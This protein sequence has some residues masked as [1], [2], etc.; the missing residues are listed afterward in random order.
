[1]SPYAPAVGYCRPP[2]SRIDET[3]LGW[4]ASKACA[5]PSR[6]HRRPGTATRRWRVRS[7]DDGNAR[8]DRP[9][10]GRNGLSW[11]SSCWRPTALLDDAGVTGHRGHRV[12]APLRRCATLVAD[13]SYPGFVDLPAGCVGAGRFA[14]A[15]R[16]PRSQ[17]PNT[18]AERIARSRV[19]D[20]DVPERGAHR[21]VSRRPHPDVR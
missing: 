8:R 18:T 2:R 15:C 10:N 20:P 3:A 7:A 6:P 12:E 9:R 16:Y 5:I 21:S 17:Q 1:M 4:C 13:N 11:G 14:N 19:A